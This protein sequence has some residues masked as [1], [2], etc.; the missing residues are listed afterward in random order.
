MVNVGTVDSPTYLPPEVG[1]VMPAQP[2]KAKLDGDQTAQMIKAA[3]RQPY[4]N[5]NLIVND[6]YQTVGLSQEGN[7]QLV[8]EI[9]LVLILNAY[10]PSRPSSASRFPNL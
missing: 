9:S 7:L 6:G 5:A 1:V 8:G 10:T 3:V 2:S 4:Q